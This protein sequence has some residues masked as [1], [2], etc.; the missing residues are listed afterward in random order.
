MNVG[1]GIEQSWSYKE[2][3]YP[4]MQL[5]K[6]EK[7]IQRQVGTDGVERDVEVEVEVVP[8]RKRLF[9]FPGKCSQH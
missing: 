1:M 5:T 4:I 7:R 8:E 3:L 2:S 9:L 6:K